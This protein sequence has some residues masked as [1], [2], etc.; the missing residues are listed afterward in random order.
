MLGPYF[1]EEHVTLEKTRSGNK[2]IALLFL[3]P[4]RQVGFD[5]QGH[6]PAILPPGKRLSTIKQEAGWA[7]APMW[8]SAENFNPTGIRSPDRPSPTES[9]Y[10]LIYPDPLWRHVV[11]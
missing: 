4:R 2:G 5:S 6:A 3:Q 1:G 7:P 10:R 8:T 9:L 11:W